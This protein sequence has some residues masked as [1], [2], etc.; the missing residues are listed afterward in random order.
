MKNLYPRG[1]PAP[2]RTALD[3]L[4][5]AERKEN[6]KEHSSDLFSESEDGN[7]VNTNDSDSSGNGTRFAHRT[8]IF[9]LDFPDSPRIPK[10]KGKKKTSLPTSTNT[11]VQDIDS[12]ESDIVTVVKKRQVTFGFKHLKQRESDITTSDSDA[13]TLMPTQTQELTVN[14]V[15]VNGSD[16]DVHIQPSGYITHRRKRKRSS[17][18]RTQDKRM[19]M[20]ERNESVINKGKFVLRLLCIFSSQHI[21]Q[22]IELKRI[23]H[24]CRILIILWWEEEFIFQHR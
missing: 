3:D 21:F 12:S 18:S 22:F 13:T 15:P 6:K 4:L 2:M 1:K 14:G 20:T 24:T 17:S 7:A 16:S 19:K 23:L 9:S 11:K 8:G 10:G 5:S